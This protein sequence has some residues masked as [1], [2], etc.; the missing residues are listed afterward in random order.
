MA[1]GLDG[2]TDFWRGARIPPSSGP[3]AR[4]GVML[5]DLY[6]PRRS[7]GPFLSTADA[8]KHQ[9][10]RRGT[11]TTT[12][13]SRKA[14]A[15]RPSG[16][17]QPRVAARYQSFRGHSA[18]VMDET[19]GVGRRPRAGRVQ[20]HQS[21]GRDTRQLVLLGRDVHQGGPAAA[22]PAR[23]RETS[24]GPARHLPDDACPPL[25]LD[26]RSAAFS[27]LTIRSIRG[28]G[29]PGA[30]GHRLGNRILRMRRLPCRLF[31]E[32]VFSPR[33]GWRCATAGARTA[34]AGARR[35]RRRRQTPGSACAFSQA[36]G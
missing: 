30:S 18:P 29:G 9:R 1:S 10:L 2:G 23:S 19:A 15:S 13:W 5:A 14:Q 11:A 6:T 35:A 31:L 25:Q 28:P 36:R 7:V 26:A 22:V 21:L 4:S 34:R 24:A 3:R 32:Q 33:R 17:D 16:F 12:T 20:P 8:G 27:Y